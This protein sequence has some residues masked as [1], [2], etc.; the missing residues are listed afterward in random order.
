MH[1]HA[2]LGRGPRV[3]GAGVRVVERAVCSNGWSLATCSR[4]A[5]IIRVTLPPVGLISTFS[6]CAKAHGGRPCQ[7]PLLCS[8][9]TEAIVE[10]SPLWHAWLTIC[11]C[12]DCW[13][14][15]S[16]PTTSSRPSP[17][18]CGAWS[19]SITSSARSTSVNGFKPA[20]SID[21]VPACAAQGRPPRGFST[22]GPD[23]WTLLQT[24]HAN[25]SCRARCTLLPAPCRHRRQQ[26]HGPRC[27]GRLFS[28]RRRCDLCG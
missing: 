12:V 5:W 25:S 20:V 3:A 26:E 27:G 28:A 24:E 8:R 11:S 4:R 6:P 15:C 23:D 10:I 21:R 1:A 9:G 18:G 17:C 22:S 7:V 2:G 13:Q 14:K 19:I 16:P